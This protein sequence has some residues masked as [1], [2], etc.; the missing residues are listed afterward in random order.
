MMSQGT[1]SA[2]WLCECTGQARSALYSEFLSITCQNPH[3]D[4]VVKDPQE[5]GCLIVPLK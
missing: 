3:Q 1:V 2:E 4:W 5:A